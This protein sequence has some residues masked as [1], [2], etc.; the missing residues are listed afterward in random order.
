MNLLDLYKQFKNTKQFNSADIKGTIKVDDYSFEIRLV[1][2]ELY[3]NGLLLAD[4]IDEAMLTLDEE[5]AYEEAIQ[6]WLNSLSSF[7][8]A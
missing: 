4:F 7:Q 2:G 6:N 1:N 8:V 5:I 3:A